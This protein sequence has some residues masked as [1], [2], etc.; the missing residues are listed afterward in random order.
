MKQ[1]LFYGCTDKYERGPLALLKQIHF[2]DGDFS[3]ER[4][5]ADHNEH[6]LR[7]FKSG[8]YSALHILILNLNPAVGTTE[9]IR[10]EYSENPLKQRVVI[11]PAAKR[12]TPVKKTLLNNPHYVAFE[13]A[14]QG[15]NP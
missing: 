9:V 14:M 11:N 7:Y 8:E 13:E 1:F 6:Y 15:P 5:A 12:T 2:Y 3:A 10:N 4:N